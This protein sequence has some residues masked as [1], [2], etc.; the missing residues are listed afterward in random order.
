MN[1]NYVNKSLFGLDICVL[2]VY[3]HHTFNELTLRRIQIG[4]TTIC[5]IIK[6]SYNLYSIVQSSCIY[7]IIQHYNI[8]K[9]SKYDDFSF[10]KG[11][12]VEEKY[13]Y[14]IDVNLVNEQS[15]YNNNSSTNRHINHFFTS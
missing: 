7:Y 12:G 4:L 10:A 14:I 13:R 5:P 8:F 1:S 3:I 15:V 11:V 6:L 9:Y 2:C